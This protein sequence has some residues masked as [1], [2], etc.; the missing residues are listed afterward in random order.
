M[1]DAEELPSTV[2]SSVDV[3]AVSDIIVK[4]R[5]LTARSESHRKAEKEP[6]MRAGEMVDAFF[7]SRAKEPLDL[8]RKGLTARLDL[9]KQR[10][11]AEERARREAE[12]AAA[13]SAAEEAR[14]LREEAEAGHGALVRRRTSSRERQR[15]PR[16]GRGARWPRPRPRK[17]TGHNGEVGPNGGRAVRGVRA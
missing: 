17:P 16:S 10:Q 11:L 2:E 5:D 1:A 13:R 7:F 15:L 12:A 6:Y 8:K 14:K 3:G 4:M 9:Y